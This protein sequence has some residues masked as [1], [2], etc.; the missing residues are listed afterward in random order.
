[1]PPMPKIIPI[2]KPKEA[3]KPVGFIRKDIPSYAWQ[4]A[5]PI[6]SLEEMLGGRQVKMKKTRKKTKGSKKRRSKR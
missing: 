5:N 1:M 2:L 4:L 3:K 6:A